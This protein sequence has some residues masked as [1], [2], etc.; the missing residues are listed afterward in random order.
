MADREH[1][2]TSISFLFIK[3][4]YFNGEFYKLGEWL[5]HLYEFYLNWFTCQTRLLL[6]FENE[7]FAQNMV[8]R[9]TS[10]SAVTMATIHLSIQIWLFLFIPQGNL[11]PHKK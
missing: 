7:T 1:S 8:L 4:N 3:P 9:P 10:S 11:P 6:L 2:K 5:Y